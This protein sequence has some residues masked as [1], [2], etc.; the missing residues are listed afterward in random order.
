MLGGQLAAQ[1]AAGPTMSNGPERNR[2]TRRSH[3]GEPTVGSKK[4]VDDAFPWEQISRPG[5]FFGYS[6]CLGKYPGD[7]RRPAAMASTLCN[8]KPAAVRTISK[9]P[10]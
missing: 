6:G 3:E 1:G 10:R 7:P 5:F 9:G 4:G 8:L 2:C